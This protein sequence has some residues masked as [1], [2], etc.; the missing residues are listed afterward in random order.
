MLAELRR[1]VVAALRALFLGSPDYRA[2]DAAAFVGQALPLLRGGQRTMTDLVAAYLQQ[3]ASA[4]AQSAG[5]VGSLVVATPSM[6]GLDLGRVGVGMREVYTRP[7]RQVW[8]E[9]SRGQ[10]MTTAVERGATRL[11]E[12]AE[13][14]L[15]NTEAKAFAYAMPSM[16]VEVRPA[17]WRRVPRGDVTCAMCILASTQRYR[18][19]TLK[20]IHPG[21]D[22]GVAVV[23]RG[24]PDPLDDTDQARYDAAHAAAVELTGRSDLGGRLV[25]YRKIPITGQ[26][27]EIAAP[28][29]RR[30]GD[31][32]T[33]AADLAAGRGLAVADA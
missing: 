29:L 28:L 4:A 6:L 10:T 14:D 12:V 33:T 24:Q 31:Q 25:D 16:A 20:P 32:F 2:A 23:Y 22:C 7:Y 9:V 27:S 21:C 17:Y 11:A 8:L 1:Q 3:T 30:P 5:G 19:D 13:L 18:V 26:H 15:Q